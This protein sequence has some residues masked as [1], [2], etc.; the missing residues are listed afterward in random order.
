[1][2]GILV[3]RSMPVTTNGLVRTQ[4]EDCYKL[5]FHGNRDGMVDEA[6]EPASRTRYRTARPRTRHWRVND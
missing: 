2:G 4:L 6:E 5:R 3:R 1:M